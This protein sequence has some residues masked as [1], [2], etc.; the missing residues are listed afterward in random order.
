LAAI[1]GKVPVI[2]SR[3]VLIKTKVSLTTHFA[4]GTICEFEFARS[5]K[6][7]LSRQLG[8]VRIMRAFFAKQARNKVFT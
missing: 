5:E 8:Q 7:L 2:F 4:M 3:I 1:Q 6:S